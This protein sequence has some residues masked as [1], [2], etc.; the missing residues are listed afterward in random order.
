MHD[1]KQYD[2]K[3]PIT[4]KGRQTDSTVVQPAHNKN[5]QFIPSKQNSI[6]YW[7]LTVATCF[8]LS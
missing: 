2:V 3:F 7:Y 8:G 6:R 1:S 4:F 5:K